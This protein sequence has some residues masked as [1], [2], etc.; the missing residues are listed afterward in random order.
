MFKLRKWFTLEVSHQLTEHKG[1]CRNLHGH[2][3]KCYLEIE[4]RDLI[5]SGPMQN[6]ILDF[7]ILSAIVKHIQDKYDHQHL[8]EAIPSFQPTSEYLAALILQDARNFWNNTDLIDSEE[9]QP[10]FN[11]SA[12]GIFETEDSEVRYESED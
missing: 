7:S 5:E 1:K 8:N 4:G 9:P 6:M 3:L 11:F 10:C 12:V 2:S